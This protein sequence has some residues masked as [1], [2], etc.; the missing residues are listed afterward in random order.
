MLFYPLNNGRLFCTAIIICP[1][2]PAMPIP[3]Q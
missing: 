1:N 2:A 3:D